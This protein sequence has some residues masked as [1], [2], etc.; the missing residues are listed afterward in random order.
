M[1][2][3]CE[4]CRTKFRLDDSRIKDNGVKVRCAKC[5]HIFTVTKEQPEAL[6]P[7]DFGTV[8]DQ[9]SG[10][11]E[12]TSPSEPFAQNQ[13]CSLPETSS[14][15]HEESPI[16]P[17]YVTPVNVTELDFSAFDAHKE[18]AFAPEPPKTEFTF[19]SLD[20]QTDTTQTSV[21]QAPLTTDVID[22]DNVGKPCST[23]DINFGADLSAVPLQPEK[24]EEFKSSQEFI[25]ATPEKPQAAEP[26]PI[27]AEPTPHTTPQTVSAEPPPILPTSA[28][29]PE[30]KPA[31]EQPEPAKPVAGQIPPTVAEDELPPLSIPSRRKDSTLLKLLMFLLVVALLGALGYYS[32]G[33]YQQMMPKTAQETGKITLRSVNSSF[34]KNTTTGS[35]LLVISGEV[36]NGFTTPRAALQVKGMVYG[37]KDQVLVSKNA[38]C[39]NPLSA[40]QLAS[41]PLDAIETAM[42]NQLGSGLSNLEVAPG[43]AIPFTVVITTLPAGAKDFGVEPAGSQAITEKSK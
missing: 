32:K 12:S 42:A 14:E 23:D 40:E 3:Q 20:A 38:F 7:S 10:F 5:R 30:I 8:L 17:P 29:Q 36:V 9:T 27:V 39:G 13:E 26:P 25:F 21:E 24:P 41:M 22:S 31:P 18:E 34:V 4:Q 43:K 35:E 11:A 19:G 37:D 15:Q 6:Q 2:I 33:L 1:I 28:P 16:T